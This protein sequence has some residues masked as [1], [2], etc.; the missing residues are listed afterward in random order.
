MSAL[1]ALCDYALYKSTFTLHYITSDV[2]RNCLNWKLSIASPI[3]FRAGLDHA[4]AF[5][6]KPL[7]KQLE[8][9]HLVSAQMVCG[10]VTGQRA[11]STVTTPR[12]ARSRLEKQAECVGSRQWME[13][14]TYNS[15][16]ST[17]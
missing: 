3:L 11:R 6:R 4:Q 9:G 2:R 7:Y 1:E 5:P 8:T 16:N 17:R 13:C 14:E 15:N 12:P 10:D